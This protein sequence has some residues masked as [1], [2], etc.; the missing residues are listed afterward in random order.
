[1]HKTGMVVS[2]L[3]MFAKRSRAPMVMDELGPALEGC[4]ML[5]LNGDIFD[6]K[7]TTLES[8]PHTID[9]ALA[10]LEGL[11][12]GFPGCRIYFI[13]GNHDCHREFTVVL[14]DLSQKISSFSWHER[15]LRLGT[16]AFLHGDC[17]HKKVFEKGLAS[18]R[19]PWKEIKKKGQAQNA[20][21]E[22]INHTGLTKAAPK[23]AFKREKM[24]GRILD[25]LDDR[26][27]GIVEKINDVYVG[28]THVPFT[29]FSFRGK[30]FHN[31]GSAIKNQDFNPLHF[32][33]AC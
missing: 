31:T 24:A 8:I 28:H 26:E 10:W 30:V 21:Y 27:P 5:V 11:V 29:D 15:Y 22:A 6:F 16:A 19:K 9:Q 18:Y 13:L 4:E 25:Y 17:I 23:I 14:E 1:M 7:W 12:K 32:R 20:I 3:H 2:D 33:A